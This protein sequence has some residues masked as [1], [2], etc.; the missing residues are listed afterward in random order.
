MARHTNNARVDVF[1]LIAAIVALI[2]AASSRFSRHAVQPGR[3]D[4]SV[5]QSGEALFGKDIMDALVLEFEEQNP[6]LRIQIAGNSNADIVFFEDGEISG[7][8]AESALASLGPYANSETPEK[9][10]AIPL[11]SFV[12]VFLY[13]IDILQAANGDR[14]PKT[15]ADFLAAARAVAAQ[16]AAQ[17][18]ALGLSR[19]DPLA[20]RRELYPW[21]WAAGGDLRQEGV[22]QDGEESVTLSRAATDAIAFFGQ[23]NREGLLAPGSL[24]QTRAQRLAEFAGGNIAMMAAS[25]RDIPLL[26][27]S[28]QGVN[29]GV[30]AMPQTAQ[31]KNR[32]GL[33]GIYAGISSACAQPDEAW[34]FLA[35][36]AGRKQAL[37]EALGAVP[38][39]YPGTFPA[40][41][42]TGDPLYSKAWDIFEAADVVEYHPAGPLE[43]ETSRII[44]EKLEEAFE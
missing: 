4:I 34:A 1:L 24:E 12:D 40:D 36:V 19:E 37:E 5:S 30:T 22:R 35:F 44:R 31:G 14:P 8:L 43:E 39:S 18:L 38:G 6:A 3:I 17:P 11:V 21:I 32:L 33:S 27:R 2:I 42:I 26:Q 25:S 20:L 28:A 15:R 7:L 9:Q 29:F 16:G 23:L 13:N 41:Y 10:W